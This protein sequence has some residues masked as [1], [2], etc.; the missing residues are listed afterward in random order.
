MD[1]SVFGIGL[2]G[3]A[4]V[5]RLLDTGHR[6]TVYNRTRSKASALAERGARVARTPHE[7]ANAA[8]VIVLMLTDAAAIADVILS[9]N[10]AAALAYKTVVQMGTIAPSESLALDQRIRAEGGDYLEAPVLG[11]IPEAREGSLLVLV[12]G[13]EQQYSRRLALLQ[14]LGSQPLHVGP[15][16]QAAAVKLALNQLIASLTAGFSLSLAMMLRNGIEVET[17]MAILRQSALYAPT[18]DK[19]LTRMLNRDFSSPNFSAKH[20]LKD[21]ELFLNEAKR[22]GLDASTLEGTRAILRKTVNAG[23]SEDDYSALYNAINPAG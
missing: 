23:L 3:E 8:E 21:V 17:F 5:Q 10:A 7:A 20:L 14:S 11:S 2:M 18:F 9:D 12:G 19:K 1:V 13:T 4:I 15:V 6:V 16:G 22:L